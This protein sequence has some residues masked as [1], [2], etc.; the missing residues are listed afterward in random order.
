MEVHEWALWA[1]EVM[2]EGWEGVN[3]T[4]YGLTVSNIEIDTVLRFANASLSN[5]DLNAARSRLRPGTLERARD[6]NRR[7]TPSASQPATD[8]YPSRPSRR[9]RARTKS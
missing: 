4:D 5:A 7:N 8:H 1:V 9:T 3:K 2:G 6:G